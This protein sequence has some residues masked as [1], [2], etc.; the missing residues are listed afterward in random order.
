MDFPMNYWIR[1][2]HFNVNLTGNC[3]NVKHQI[4][5][6]KLRIIL[7]SGVA[8]ETNLMSTRTKTQ[9]RSV[10]RNQNLWSA[11]MNSTR[12]CA[13]RHIYDSAAS[14]GLIWACELV[15]AEAPDLVLYFLFSSLSA[16]TSTQLSQ[17][18]VILYPEGWPSV[19]PQPQTT[20]PEERLCVWQ[21]L[22]PGYNGCLWWRNFNIWL[23]ILASQQVELWWEMFASY[24]SL[25]ISI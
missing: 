3:P 16:L 13:L 18:S 1:L 10:M 25:H 14:C 11:H 24:L 17:L 6:W 12:Q 23:Q 8:S 9:F 21:F 4:G 22:S 19:A 15:I 7:F 2:R 20:P 5:N